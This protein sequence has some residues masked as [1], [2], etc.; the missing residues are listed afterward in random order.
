MSVRG[1][2]VAWIKLDDGF[3]RHP[4]VLAAGRDARDLYLAGLCYCGANLTDGAIPAN[5]LR[6]LGAE[7]EI[8]DAGAAADRLVEVGL[9]KRGDSGFAVHDFLAYNPTRDRV[10]ATRESR[11]EAG[12]LGGKQK[13]SN[14]LDASL[15]K[16]KQKSAPLRSRIESVNENGTKESVVG[17]SEGKGAAADAASDSQSDKILPIP[18]PKATP[19]PDDFTVTE[20][21]AEFAAGLGLS[22]PQVEFETAKFRDHF[23]SKQGERKTDWVAAWRNWM[24]RVGE[25]QPA[26][27]KVRTMNGT[28]A[29]A[30][31]GVVSRADKDRQREM[32]G[33]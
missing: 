26:P 9:W 4:K 23:G 16:S 13:A 7:A 6:V 12:R 1:T 27:A 21:M 5:A 28:R 17:E 14:L 15:A 18:K 22:P 11:A 32:I 25:F 33:R 2:A 30:P 8:D 10:L 3:F 20:T 31:P 19:I 24:R 29:A